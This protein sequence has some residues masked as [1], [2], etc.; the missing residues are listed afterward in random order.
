MFTKSQPPKGE[1]VDYDS[2]NSGISGAFHSRRRKEKGMRGERND[3]PT[4]RHIVERDV[5]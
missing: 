3:R 2:E 4:Q 1:N 5:S